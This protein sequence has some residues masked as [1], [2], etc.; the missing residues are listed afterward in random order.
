MTGG[1]PWK[2]IL[3]FSWPVFAG[4]VL[5]QLYNTA[6]SV[7][8]GNF[9]GEKALSA[10]GTT[11]TLIFFFLAIAIGVSAGNGVLAAQH[12]GAGNM[13]ELRRDAQTGILL[14]L[15]IGLL[16]SVAG[17]VFSR[18]AYVQ[19]V[20][21]PP[22][23]L[24]QT[25]LYF[26]IYC[27][28]LLFQFGYNALA[29]LLRSVGD[30]AA[31]LYFLLLASLLN[32]GLDLLFVGLFKWSVAGAAA[33]TNIAQASCMAA[34]W[35]YM[36]KKYPVFRI[37]ITQMR[38]HPAIA[39]DILRLGCP[40]AL[41]LMIVAIGI[42]FIQRA[43]NSFGQVMTAAF[44]V[45]QRIEMYLHLPCNSLMTTLSAYTGQNVG[46]CRM[47]RVKAGM[48]QG[49]M[50]SAGLTAVLSVPVWLLAEDL[51]GWFALSE[52]AAEYCTSYL[53]AAALVV[54]ILSL[55]VPLFGVFQG[56]RHVLVPALVALF[57][58]ALRVAV[59][60]LFKD[61]SFLGHTIIW[62]NG[63][64][65]FSLGCIISWIYFFSGR[66]RLNAGG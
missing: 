18:W 49:V 6:D 47:D 26:R 55:Y 29:A 27:A 33:A 48:L 40:I 5:Q 10:V 3:G 50:L 31:T 16:A 64:F 25:L 17:I 32:V 63:L 38:W 61:S 54:M 13:Q 43:V 58:L 35:I 46:A 19:F 45:G 51:P 14:M 60:Y 9:S 22:E 53:K 28:G 41:Q 37:R 65:G 42:T 2:H 39:R 21:V 15:L 44:A 57:A 12:F 34:A 24:D 59:T 4:A 36:H 30:S 8:V 52:Q 66:W 62:W 11:N 7:I 56:T 23:I 1:S 20:A